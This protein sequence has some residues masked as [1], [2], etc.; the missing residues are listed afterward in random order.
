MSV[1]TFAAPA[2]K[3]L[4]DEHFIFIEINVDHE[5]ETAAWFQGETIPDTRFLSPEGRTLDQ[6]A[7]F[8]EPSAFAVRLKKLVEG[9]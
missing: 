1:K 9:K 5:K 6:V 3:K 7:G 8:E 2:V 4:I